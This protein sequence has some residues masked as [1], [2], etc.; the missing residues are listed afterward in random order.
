MCITTIK[1]GSTFPVVLRMIGFGV[2]VFREKSLHPQ[3]VGVWA[4]VSRARIIGPIFFNRTVDSG[5][6][7]DMVR[8]FIA[9]LPQEDRYCY[10]HEDGATAHE[11]IDFFKEI[12]D[13]RLIS[14]PHW[15]PRSPDLTPPDFSPSGYLKDRV[16]SMPPGTL[17]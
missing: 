4:A 11:T 5:V 15:R 3:N 17:E 13:D 8:H 10:I 14:R 2:K 16:F 12:F 6:Y 7:H 1:H 9:L